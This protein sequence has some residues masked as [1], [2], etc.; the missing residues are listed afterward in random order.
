MFA[1]SNVAADPTAVLRARV[2]GESKPLF[3]SGLGCLGFG[4]LI[5]LGLLLLI[6][7]TSRLGV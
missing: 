6:V 3:T 4:L 7:L 5:L 2:G 1:E